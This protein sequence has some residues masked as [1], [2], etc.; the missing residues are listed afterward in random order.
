MNNWQ[1]AVSIMRRPINLRKRKRLPIAMQAKLFETLADLLGNGFSFQQAFQFTLDVEGPAFQSL[2]PA[3][4]RLAAGDD[5]STA[6]RPYIAVDLYYQFLIAETHGE[7]RR[8]L[9]QAGQLMRA[10]AEQGRQIRRLL[11]Y[12]C[13][14]L[15]LLLG[16]L[17]TVKA[18]ILPS[19]AHGG[20]GSGTIANWQWFSGITVITLVICLLLVGLQVSRLPIRRRYQWLAQVPLIGPLIRNYCGYYLSLNAGM[21]LTGGL[22]IRGICEVSQH[23]QTKALIYQQGQVIEQALLTGTS[24]VTIIQEDRLLPD[25]LALLVG[26]ESPAEQLSQELLYFAVRT[27]DST[28]EPDDWLDSTHHVWHYCTRRCRHILEFVITD[29]S[30]NGGD[31]KMTLLM[32]RLMKKTAAP[33]RGFTLI[34]MVIVL[35]II[36][37][38]MLIVV[39]NLNQQRKQAAGRQQEALTEV[40]QNQA[41]MYA[42]DTGKTVTD[43]DAMLEEL[44]N[45]G[46]INDGQ[47]KQAKSQGI[48]PV[49]PQPQKVV[50]G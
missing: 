19:L 39:P 23:F 13:L 41:E 47:Y 14:L 18:A 38:L 43:D 24:L 36:S 25:E 9:M 40:V 33:Q 1:R 37:L 6:L 31:F 22:G 49:R 15:I 8:T 29:V 7:L 10:R 20:N 3:L 45:K 27:L 5:L 11:Q 2:Q 35:A 17:G 30:I 42:N 16:T 21:L 4:G 48:S 44:R 28:V 26:K 34:E 12:P 46:Y 32:K 50:G